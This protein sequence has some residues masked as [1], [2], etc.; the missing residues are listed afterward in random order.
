MVGYFL[1]P[2][3]H[4]NKT[5]FVSS[6]IFYFIGEPVYVFLLLFSILIDYYHSSIIDV[7]YGKRKAK[8][9]LISSIVMN[10][11]L[12][13]FF[14][15]SDFI[16]QNIN[17]LLSTDIPLLKIPL[18]IGISFFTFQTMSYTIDVYRGKAKAQKSFLGLGTYVSLFPQLIAGPIVRYQDVSSDLLQRQHSFEKVYYGLTRFMVGLSKKVIFANSF[19]ILANEIIEATQPDV[20]L[21]W[22]SAAAYMLQ[23]YYD[24]SGYSDMAIGLGSIFGFQFPEN[25]R[26]PYSAGSITEFWRRWHIT[27]GQWFRDYVYVPLGGSRNG[28][29]KTGF[30]LLVVWGL[31]GLW[32]GASWN[33]IIWGIGFAVILGLE[34]AVIL[35]ILEKMPRSF[36]HFYVIILV[37]LS[38]VVFRFDDLKIVLSVYQ[39]MF[40]FLDIPAFSHESLYHLKSYIILFIIGGIGATPIIAHNI[41]KT[42][43]HMK[44][45]KWLVVLEAAGLGFLYLLSASYLVDDSF[46]PFLYFRF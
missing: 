2:D 12:L 33:F 1:T 29:L 14:K 18:P 35:R 38:F 22:L 21:Y 32:H 40:G 46:N 37:M 16:L 25:F 13:S 43:K 9:T 44:G 39:G 28:S 11:G 10:V 23:I 24:F 3:E 34:K 26:Y 31:T 42:I 5:L 17:S 19:G 6:I 15:Y 27:L 41:T 30:N 8:I 20:L 4:K 36:R 7:H 45:A